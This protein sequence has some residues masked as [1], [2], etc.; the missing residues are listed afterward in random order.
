MGIELCCTNHAESLA[1]IQ[2]RAI[3]VLDVIEHDV[4]GCH[5]IISPYHEHILCM[6]ASL[7]PGILWFI[8]LGIYER[9]LNLERLFYRSICI[10][11]KCSFL[12][13]NVVF[14]TTNKQDSLDYLRFL[15]IH[16]ICILSLENV[17]DSSL[18]IIG[19][20]IL[21]S[22]QRIAA[23]NEYGSISPVVTHRNLDWHNSFK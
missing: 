4:L 8:N 1:L 23:H 16:R 9:S 6:Y 15:N 14:G 3:I 22:S 5:Y 21:R 18:G 10:L 13:F 20:K 17:V 7:R 12:L 2:Y 19:C 11:L